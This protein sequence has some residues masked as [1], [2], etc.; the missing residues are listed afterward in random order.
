LIVPPL[1]DQNLIVCL[2]I[3]NTTFFVFEGSPTPNHLFFL[4]LQTPFP[5]PLAYLGFPPISQAMTSSVSG[6]T[7]VSPSNF[8]LTG[9]PRNLVMAPPGVLILLFVFSIKCASHY[10]LEP[11]PNFFLSLPP[12]FFFFFFSK[13]RGCSTLGVRTSRPMEPLGS[14]FGQAEVFASSLAGTIFF[15][16]FS[17]CSFEPLSAVINAS[18]SP[19]RSF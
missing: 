1:P 14:Y 3:F 13:L 7:A 17:S 19:N 6:T 8:S 4:S 12:F 5:E 15:R 9:F 2:I 16:P 11:V 10:G 18:P